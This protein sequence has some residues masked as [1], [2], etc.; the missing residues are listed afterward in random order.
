MIGIGSPFGAD[1][2]GWLVIDALRASSP[3]LDAS[4]V[5]CRHPG[6]LPDLLAGYRR[7]ILVDA[8]LADRPPGTLLRLSRDDLPH[9]G[10]G[11]SSHGLGVPQALALAAV[12]GALPEQLQVLGIE[13]GKENQ[14]VNPAWIER[15]AGEVLQDLL[16]R[17]G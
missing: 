2:L 10:L 4:L 8:V 5:Q 14:P 15:L 7:A 12:L 17:S 9:V 1:Q 16:N 3:S 6:E 13:I 11:V